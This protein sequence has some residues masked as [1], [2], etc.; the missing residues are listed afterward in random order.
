MSPTPTQGPLFVVV[1][2]GA[3]HSGI[4]VDVG[5]NVGVAVIVLVGVKVLVAVLVGVM[6]LVT[7][8]VNVLVGVMVGVMVL[9]GVGVVGLWVV[10]LAMTDISQAEV[11]ITILITTCIQKPRLHRITNTQT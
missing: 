2:V 4:D 6:V 7:V 10:V 11:P 3:I 1:P 8:G 5:V 9:V